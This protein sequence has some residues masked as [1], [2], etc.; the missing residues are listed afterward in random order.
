MHTTCIQH[1]Y[2]MHTDVFC[3]ESSVTLQYVTRIERVK[4]HVFK[5]L[6]QIKYV[7]FSS[8]QTILQL[9]NIDTHKKMY[10]MVHCWYTMVHFLMDTFHILLSQYRYIILATLHI[11]NYKTK[12]HH[13]NANIQLNMN[14]TKLYCTV[15]HCSHKTCLQV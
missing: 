7:Y 10:H 1:A 15:C 2:N 4:E 3:S 13:I 11:F 9:K 8:R 5:I 6:N 12:I 14:Y